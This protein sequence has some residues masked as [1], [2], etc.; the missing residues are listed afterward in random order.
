MQNEIKISA[1]AKV[2]IG[3]LVLPK[4]SDGFHNIESIFQT[5]NIADNLLVK[6]CDLKGECRVFCE[7]MILPAENTISMAYKAFCSVTGKD[8]SG[9]SVILEKN[10]P[11]G[12]G[13][14]GGSSDAAAFVRALEKLS[15]MHLTNEQIDKISSLVGSDVY[16]FLHCGEQGKGCA[17]VSGR[18][19]VVKPI[20]IRNDLF[21]LL[22]FP[23]VHSST[24]EA[25]TLVDEQL[26][27]GIN[28]VNP[29]YEEFETMYN[30]PVYDWTFRNSFTQALV[31]RYSEIGRALDCLKKTK[32]MYSEM[33]GS[34]SVT[35]GVYSSY[36]EVLDAKRFIESQG[37]RCAIA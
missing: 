23:G 21:F 9:I 10:I 35:F 5:V 32:A 15:N 2:N 36:E 13:L 19:E 28:V 16:F 27:E 1:L 3:L 30:G 25:Y 37:F 4:R 11:A 33:S 22:V 20:L 7:S 12:G 14:G 6:I 8:F 34:G 29:K 26:A 17:K 24:K 31:K 18:G